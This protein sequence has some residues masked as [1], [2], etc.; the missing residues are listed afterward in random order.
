MIKYI[1][2][3]FILINIISV[4]VFCIDKYQAI[5]TK[6]R[7]PER[8]LHFLELLGGVFGIL[9]TMRI[10]HHK[11]SKSQ[12]YCITYLI[13]FIWVIALYFFGD[14]IIDLIK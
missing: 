3:Y 13:L 11:N 10:I 2:A 14:N 5:K 9:I 6:Q 1:I 4:L 7:V 8:F 12:Y